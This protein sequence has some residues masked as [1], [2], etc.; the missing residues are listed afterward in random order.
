MSTITALGVRLDL[1]GPRPV[2]PPH[3]L[4]NTPGVVVEDGEGRW[5]NGVVLDTYPTDPP[6][7][8]DPC[9]AGT[10]RV[11]DDGANRELPTFDAFVVYVPTTCSFF[12]SNG[13]REMTRVALEANA[14]W[15][16]EFG[17]S[18]GVVG[19][20]NPSLG[21]AN[22]AQLGANGISA[23]EG[24][25]RLEN[26]IG[27]TG[28]KGVIHATPAIVSVLQTDKLEG[29]EEGNL[30]TAN[31]TPVVA[32]GGY[33]GVHPHAKTAPSDGQDWM[34][35]TGPVEVRLGPPALSDLVSSLDRSDNT[36]TFRAERAVLPVWDTAL[37]VGVLVD[38]AP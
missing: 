18:H 6:A 13:L 4:L 9:S 36:V 19:L 3:S 5:M 8:W 26:A 23:A 20:S 16:V 17:L 27:A 1:T 37:Q 29:D 38:W 30:L 15:G 12:S 31:G 25:A 11:K 34:F 22:L 21:D 24:L 33:I 14:S 2:A 32:G 28:I 35:A 10:T 7:V